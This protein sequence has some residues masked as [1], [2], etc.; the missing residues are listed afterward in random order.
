MK[1]KQSLI[2]NKQMLDSHIQFVRSWKSRPVSPWQTHRRLLAAVSPLM[3]DRTGLAVGRCRWRVMACQRWTWGREETS[4][5]WRGGWQ[6][7]SCLS[8]GSQQRG[9]YNEIVLKGPC[10]APDPPVSVCLFI[11]REGRQCQEAGTKDTELWCINILIILSTG[12][13]RLALDLV[14]IYW[15]ERKDL[16]LIRDR[17]KPNL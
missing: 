16:R 5:W 2:C 14:L 7:N 1:I 15:L 10:W 4:W 9:V 17:L 11:C 12:I 3:I 8:L 13:L 6:D